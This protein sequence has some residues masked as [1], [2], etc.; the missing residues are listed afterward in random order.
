[1]TLQ[2]SSH[3]KYMMDNKEDTEN[4]RDFLHAL[5][6]SL[7][8]PYIAEYAISGEYKGLLDACFVQ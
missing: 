2:H 8:L 6:K 1:M 5:Y 7:N 3:P 4:Y